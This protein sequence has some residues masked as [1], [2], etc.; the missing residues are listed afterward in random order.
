M[1][2]PNISKYFNKPILLI[3]AIRNGWNCGVIE[4][5][6]LEFIEGGERASNKL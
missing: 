5:T 4:K 6:S 2:V 3:L 1:G